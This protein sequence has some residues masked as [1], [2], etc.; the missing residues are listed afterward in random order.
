MCAE[1]RDRLPLVDH[2]TR[3]SIVF[4]VDT[5]ASMLG[6]PIDEL[7]QV[8]VKFCKILEKKW[9]AY[10][11]V[12]VISFGER[13][14]IEVGFCPAKQYKAPVLSA[15]GLTAMN[16]GILKA[17]DEIETRRHHYLE[18][19]IGYYRP[20]LFVFTDGCPTDENLESQ[21]ISILRHLIDNRKII[22]IPMGIGINSD[23]EYMKKY[24][25]E[26]WPD[27]RV[28]SIEDFSGFFDN[29]FR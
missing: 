15:N 2:E 4:L 19:G 26:D 3:I 23:Y 6:K 9:S 1:I 27:K 13:V 18:Q 14:N 5:S 8:L 16:E 17:L 25:P 22:Y 29:F 12:S 24:Y 10:A 11:D 28:F 21:A 20:W 7:N